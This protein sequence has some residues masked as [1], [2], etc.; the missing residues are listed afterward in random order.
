MPRA[1]SLAIAAAAV[2][3]A[4]LPVR[5]QQPAAQ[6]A[7]QQVRPAPPAPEAMGVS[8]KAIRK[9]LK[10]TPPVKKASGAGMRYDFFVDVL[11][12]RPAIEFFREF[13]LSTQGGVRWGG[14]THQEILDA[15]TPF[16][17]RNFGGVDVL[18]IGKKKK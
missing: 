15:V 4:A 16:P 3:L 10:D 13:D 8:L 5:A 11:G 2:F 9:Q 6:A 12:K 1:H 7:P 14:A 18:A 17:F